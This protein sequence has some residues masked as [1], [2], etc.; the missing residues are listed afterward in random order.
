MSL[1]WE[2]VVAWATS[3]FPETEESTSW[4]TPS[5]KVKGKLICRLRTEAEGSLA[6]RCSADDKIALVEGDDEAF[7]TVPHYDGY[8]YVLVR[9]EK[10]DPVEFRELFT[11]RKSVV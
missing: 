4:K 6:L 10:V 1:S 2:Q 8:N 3:S 7:F 5:L 11:D 9:L